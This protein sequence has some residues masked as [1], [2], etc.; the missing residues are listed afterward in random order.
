MKIMCITY[1]FTL[2]IISPYYLITSL[3]PSALIP[4]LIMSSN[5]SKLF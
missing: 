3:S 1:L 2:N 5:T 4:I